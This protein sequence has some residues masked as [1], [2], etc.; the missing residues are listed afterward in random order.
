MGEE[1]KGIIRGLNKGVEELHYAT[2][3]IRSMPGSDRRYFLR[4][5]EERLK[6]IASYIKEEADNLLSWFAVK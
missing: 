1:E 5:N 3:D 2:L 6:A 4:E